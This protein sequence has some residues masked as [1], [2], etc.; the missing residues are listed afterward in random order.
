MPI[1]LGRKKPPGA[2]TASSAALEMAE[3]L[4]MALSGPTMRR[5]P[6]DAL[7]SPESWCICDIGRDSAPFKSAGAASVVRGR[8]RMQGVML[9]HK[10]LVSHRHSSPL[11]FSWI[12]P[13]AACAA[14]DDDQ[15]ISHSSYNQ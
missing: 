7:P 8:G 6:L 1:R 10:L 13:G 5:L 14:R 12:I 3:C 15:G 2:L 11:Q 4:I 9:Y